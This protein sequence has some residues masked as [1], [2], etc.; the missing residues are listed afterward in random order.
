MIAVMVLV[1]FRYCATLF[2]LAAALPLEQPRP[3][4]D[5]MVWCILI[6]AV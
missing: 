2:G 4:R 5:W 6:V 1:I 3:Q